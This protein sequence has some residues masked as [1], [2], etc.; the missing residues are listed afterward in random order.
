MTEDWGRTASGTPITEELL[1]ELAAKAEAGY[2]ID[3][4]VERGPEDSTGTSPKAGPAP[5][6]A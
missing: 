4:L 2:D 6:Q 5:R 3:E 1:Q